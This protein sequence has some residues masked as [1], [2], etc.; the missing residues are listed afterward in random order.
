MWFRALSVAVVSVGGC[1]RH[2]DAA[3][4]GS[5]GTVASTQEGGA[6]TGFDTG[7]GPEIA[8][9]LGSGDA[10]TGG[11]SSPADDGSS[12]GAPVTTTGDESGGGPPGMICDDLD[13]PRCETV[14][15]ECGPASDYDT[16]YFGGAGPDTLNELSTAPA[17]V[18][19]AYGDDDDLRA[20]CN[21]SCM[22]AG[23]G[24]DRLEFGNDDP[25][26]GANIGVGGAG[27]DLWVI[28]HPSVPPTLADVESGETIGFLAIGTFEPDFLE[29]IPGFSGD[30]SILQSAHVV[31]DPNT[32][33]LWVDEDGPGASEASEI[34]AIVGNHDAVTLTLENF[35]ID[36]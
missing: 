32:G 9:S 27:N 7:S 17:S 26:A 11:S 4:G 5:E 15:P 8:T 21:A 1:S 6:S 12:S 19:F 3:D 23:D 2:D 25:E 24:D 31:Y 13:P 33:N 35:V 30:F 18:Y 29:I 20:Y 16:P 36:P 10:T 28:D 14:P 22:V 34:R